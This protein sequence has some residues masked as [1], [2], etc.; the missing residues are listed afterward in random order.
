MSEQAPEDGRSTPQPDAD[1]PTQPPGEGS[2][3]ELLRQ[4]RQAAGVELGALAQAL[5]VSPR[6]LE[7]LE[8]DRY[9]QLPD[10]VFAR[11]LAA[12]VCRALK[13]DAAPVLARLPQSAPRLSHDDGGLNAPFQAPGDLAQVP[14]WDRLSRPMVLAALAALLG[15]LVIILFPTQQQRAEIGALVQR[16]ASEP[17]PPPAVATTTS[18]V[19]A[20]AVPAPPAPATVAEP[21]PVPVAQASAPAA[22][23]SEA[24]ARAPAPGA[25]QDA[26]AEAAARKKLATSGLVV[27]KTSAPSWIEVVDAQ[28]TVQLNRILEPGEPVGVSGVPPLA[29]VVGRAEVTEVQVRGKP[30]DLTPVTRQGVARFEVK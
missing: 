4:A 27:F 6:K 21:V 2:A 8:Q 30:M 15:A 5:K 17:L 24:G 26:A 25:G 13:I 11:A 28:G 14:F 1:T 20:P 10:A 23:A 29:I 12:S 16:A 19:P 22:L 3:G 18:V 7:A 9:E